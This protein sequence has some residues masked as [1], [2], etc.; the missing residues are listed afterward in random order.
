[1]ESNYLKIFI[2]SLLKFKHTRFKIIQITSK[3]NRREKKTFC[4][5]LS[6]L[7]NILCILHFK[8]S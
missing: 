3:L 4:S 6:I 2:E 1:M 8:K 5:T 7:I